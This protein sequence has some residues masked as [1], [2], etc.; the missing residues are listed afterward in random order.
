MI[1]ENIP[2]AAPVQIDHI[3]FLHICD[4]AQ[5]CNG[6]PVIHN[7]GFWELFYVEKGLMEI[8]VQNSSYTLSNTRLYLRSPAQTVRLNLPSP[9]PAK[10]F[11]LGFTSSAP[12]FPEAA[13]EKTLP[14]GP[15]ERML[16]HYLAAEAAAAA[17][18]HTVP[19]AAG[20]AAALY[21]QLLLIRLLRNAKEKT[22]STSAQRSRQIMEE[23]DL[24]YT[25][26]AY[27]KEH[28]AERLTIEQICHDNLLGR[29]LLQKLFTDYTGCGVIDYFLLMKINAAKQLIRT[30]EWNLSR[31]SEKLGYNSIHYFSRQ[32][33]TI[34]GITP[35]EYAAAV[36]NR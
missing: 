1:Y 25:I 16:L 2:S 17:G 30:G 36:H 27:M 9:L 15:P 20:Q 22:T 24:F 35:S 10:L 34:T 29:T 23:E 13:E 14:I 32:F 31:I 6:M 28:I 7:G 3:L 8:T 12:C 18:S 11:S 19:F 5:E 21:L 26:V 4:F 33:K